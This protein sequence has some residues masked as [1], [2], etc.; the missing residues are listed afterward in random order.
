MP[1]FTSFLIKTSV[2]ISDVVIMTFYSYCKDSRFDPLKNKCTPVIVICRCGWETEER[3]HTSHS[4]CITFIPLYPVCP[5]PSRFFFPSCVCFFFLGI[6]KI[7]VI[8][9]VVM[10]LTLP[11]WWYER[12]TTSTITF[13]L[14][15][16]PNCLAPLLINVKVLYRLTLNYQVHSLYILPLVLL[17]HLTLFHHLVGHLN[18]KGWRLYPTTNSLEWPK[19]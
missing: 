7:Y 11:K 15:N 6:R 9:K 10:T 12:E 13:L 18:I 5:K 2:S 17:L 14:S 3:N 1:Y 19:E 16:H 8:W 4:N